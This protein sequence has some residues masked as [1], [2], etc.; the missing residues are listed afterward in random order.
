M[1]EE[2]QLRQQIL[3]QRKVNAHERLKG[4]LPFLI[5]V[6][7]LIVLLVQAQLCG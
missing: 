7:I 6:L 2:N 1:S 5:V 4:N 3:D